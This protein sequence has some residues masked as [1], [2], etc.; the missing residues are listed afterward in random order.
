MQ[1]VPGIKHEAA[2]ADPERRCNLKVFPT[3][4]SFSS[5]MFRN[6]N[7]AALEWLSEATLIKAQVAK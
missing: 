4:P 1:T 5:G 6:Q 7:C 2:S 3:P